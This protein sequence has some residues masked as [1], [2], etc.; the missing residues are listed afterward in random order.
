MP[1]LRYPR[2]ENDTMKFGDSLEPVSGPTRQ[3]RVASKQRFEALML[4]GTAARL[5]ESEYP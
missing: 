4:D 5:N 1:N 2:T 3:T